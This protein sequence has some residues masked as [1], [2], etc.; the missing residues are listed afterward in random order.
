LSSVNFNTQSPRQITGIFDKPPTHCD[1]A[2]NA[3]RSVQLLERSIGVVIFARSS[4]GVRAT[5]AGRHF[6]W[7]PRSIL[8]QIEALIAST[9][10]NGSDEA[11]RHV[12]GFCTSLTAGNLR[13][14]LLD[15]KKLFPP[16]RTCYRRE[17]ENATRNPVPQRSYRREHHNGLP[18]TPIS[19]TIPH[20]GVNEFWSF[21]Q[22]IIRW[23]PARLSTGRI[24]GTRLFA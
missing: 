15:F 12:I 20:S 18:A 1:R 3:Q 4:G 2:I 14:T 6:L 11:G 7:M 13:A 9:R 16:G 5:L 17:I 19:R 23:L 10:P 24:F 8:E 21:S 22:A